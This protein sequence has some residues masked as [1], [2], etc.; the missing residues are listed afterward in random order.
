MARSD[1]KRAATTYVA[2]PSQTEGLEAEIAQF[3]ARP[4]KPFRMDRPGTSESKREPG[5]STDISQAPSS[6]TAGA[7][8]IAEGVAQAAEKAI[9]GLAEGLASLLGGGS[10][11]STEPP[12]SPPPD[13]PKPR[14]SFEE[15]QAAERGAAQQRAAALQELSRLHGR[16]VIDENDAKLA[17]ELAKRRDRE[18]GG[19]Q[20]L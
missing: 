14:Q 4:I 19:G 11:A 5:R 15:F 8:K 16:E 2:D 18:R 9:E 17:E 13:A 20:S 10:A 3:D 6:P 1:G 7:A 12:A